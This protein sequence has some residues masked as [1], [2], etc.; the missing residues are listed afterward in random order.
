MVDVEHETRC[1]ILHKELTE[2]PT[3]QSDPAVVTESPN[4]ISEDK[5]DSGFAEEYA[6]FFTRRSVRIVQVQSRREYEDSKEKIATGKS[7]PHRVKLE[8]EPCQELQSESLQDLITEN[9]ELFAIMTDPTLIFPNG[10][11]N[12]LSCIKCQKL[13]VQSQAM[14]LC[15]SC[16]KSESISCFICK[17]PNPTHRCDPLL[18]CFHLYHKECFELW[19]QISCPGCPQHC[20]HTCYAKDC[21]REGS[22]MKCV[23]CPAAFHSN[24]FCL[25]A[26]SKILTKSQIVC[27]RHHLGKPKMKPLN[28]DWCIICG[29][30]GSLVCCDSCCYSFHMECIDNKANEKAFKCESCVIGRMPLNFTVV[31]AKSGNTRWWPALILPD[32]LVPPNVLDKKKQDMDICV[33]F[34]GSYKYIWT[35]SDRVFPYNGSTIDGSF[36]NSTLN[37]EYQ[38]ALDEARK[39]HKHVSLFQQ[40]TTK[41]VRSPYHE[42]SENIPVPPAEMKSNADVEVDACRCASDD[43]CGFHSGCI[44]RST[45]LECDISCKM[46]NDCRNQSIRK[47]INAK[48]KVVRT[49]ASGF[50]LFTLQDLPVG[51]FVVE[52]I[53]ELLNEAEMQRR[54][55]VM[56]TNGEKNFYFLNVT[57]D[58]YIDSFKSGNLSR[59]ANHSC[60]PNCNPEKM[61]VDG[62]TRIGIYTNCDVKAVSWLFVSAQIGEQVFIQSFI[63]LGNGADV[64]LSDENVWRKDRMLLRLSEMS[65]IYWWAGARNKTKYE[66]AQL[67]FTN[68]C[69]LMNFE[70]LTEH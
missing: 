11:A 31:W 41:P 37:S 16:D 43:P 14:N 60:D 30:F 61:I 22:L 4:E 54:M 29:D 17:K 2:S 21:V 65:R 48:L 35:T 6:E 13:I 23:E 68:D 46:G 3:M 42:I 10:L 1:F 38:V 32:L 39:L 26:G 28:I 19:P 8:V 64:Q 9:K 67:K 33:R 15:N 47:K 70:N 34:F 45:G 58:L 59:F 53:G 18:D 7:R 66:N 12:D 44:N 50:G 57:S 63:S 40:I 27:P 51:T 55:K 69:V 56:R 20:C 36:G 5:N 24:V 62:I 52:Y 49:L 25:P